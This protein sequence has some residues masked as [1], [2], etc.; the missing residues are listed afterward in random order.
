MNSNWFYGIDYNLSVSAGVQIG[1]PNHVF[2]SQRFGSDSTGD[3]S[4]GA[5]YQTILYAIQNGFGGNGTSFSLFSFSIDGVSYTLLK[6]NFSVI[7]DSG[8]YLED[9]LATSNRSRINIIANVPKTVALEQQNRQNSSSPEGFFCQGIVFYNTS[10]TLSNARSGS[11]LDC[12]FYGS[13]SQNNSQSSNSFFSHCTF[14]GSSYTS[15]SDN[16]APGNSVF[17]QCSFRSNSVAAALISTQSGNRSGFLGFRNCDFDSTFRLI[18]NEL[19][20]GTWKLEDCNFQGTVENPVTGNLSIIEIDP[21]NP[22]LDPGY[23]GTTDKGEVLEP[24][25]SP[26]IG[27]SKGA[28]S[29]GRGVYGEILDIN[30]ATLG[31]AINIDGLDRIVKITTTTGVITYAPLI[32]DQPVFSPTIVFNGIFDNIYNGI[33]SPG[34][35]SFDLGRTIPPR[36]YV[37]NASYRTFSNPG[38]LSSGTF[39]YNVPMLIGASTSQAQGEACGEPNFIGSSISST[40]DFFFLDNVTR[41]N[42]LDLLELNITVSLYNQ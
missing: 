30:Q 3:G 41:E 25:N 19:T 32:F 31:S 23:L 5:P 14:V 42:V 27:A 29:V 35:P 4:P 40:G 37:F 7:V 34:V 20:Q 26:L 22:P 28:R 2:V 11:F 6:N 10:T 36:G 24:F 21:V 38:T 9:F 8:Y 12:I 17:N 39:F 33:T 1:L 13:N 15:V 16:G 18:Q